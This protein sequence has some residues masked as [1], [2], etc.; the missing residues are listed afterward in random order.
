VA[1]H[2]L[3][4]GGQAN[5]FKAP[6][7]ADGK[8]GFIDKSR[9]YAIAPQ[10]ERAEAFSEGLAGVRIDN[11]R[12]IIQFAHQRPG[13]EVPSSK[14]LGGPDCAK[15]AEDASLVGRWI[16]SVPSAT[17]TSRQPTHSSRSGNTSS[18]GFTRSADY[19]LAHSSAVGR[20]RGVDEEFRPVAA[21]PREGVELATIL[22]EPHRT[23][24]SVIAATGLRIG[25]LL[26]L[27]TIPLGRHVVAVLT[28]HRE[29]VT[30]RAAAD[31]VFGNR[32]GDPLRESK[33]LTDV[34]QPAAKAVGLG[35]VTWHQFRH[36]HSS[37]LN[38]LKVPVKIAQ[39]QLGHASIA[40]TL[41][42]YTHVVE[43]SHRRAVEEVEQRLF[44][45]LDPNGPNLPGPPDTPTPVR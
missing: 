27:R 14:R 7:P 30:R 42:I 35:R 39:E 26:A 23:M 44:G 45:E 24:V 12:G 2:H 20:R 33:V 38:D 10:F 32:R 15:L 41:N 1:E 34:L 37:L 4:L 21:A 9:R 6:N 3:K 11:K 36:I 29:R 40:T 5:T 28:G 19:G 31:L 22:G 43:A 16:T 17:D 25:E 13:P 18:P 8:W